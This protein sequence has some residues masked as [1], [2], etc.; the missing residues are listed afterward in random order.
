VKDAVQMHGGKNGG[1]IAALVPGRTK[2]QCS[3]RWNNVL[4]P[5]ID[6]V[7]NRMGKWVE[8]E[9]M[10]LEDVVKMHGGK[11]WVAITVLVPDRNNAVAD[12]M[13]SWIPASADRLESLVVKLNGQQRKTLS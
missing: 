8:D 3:S 9:D 6:P 12:G 4:Y 7:N 11:K 2:V 10:M 13:I 1:A 5:S